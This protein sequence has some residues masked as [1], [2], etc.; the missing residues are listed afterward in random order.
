MENALRYSDIYVQWDEGS[1]RTELILHNRTVEEAINLA[2]M[3]GYRRPVWFK[4]WTYITRHLQIY[5]VK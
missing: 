2:V 5:K 3:S 4:P 1:S